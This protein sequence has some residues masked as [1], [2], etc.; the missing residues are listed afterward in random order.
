MTREVL[1]RVRDVPMM[2]RMM[3]MMMMMMMMIMMRGACPA[4]GTHLTKMIVIE[5]R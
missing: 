3:M 4:F 2:M 1:P 5:K